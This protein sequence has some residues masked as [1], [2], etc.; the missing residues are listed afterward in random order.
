MYNLKRDVRWG[1]LFVLPLWIT[2]SSHAASILVTAETDKSN[3]AVG[4]TTVVTVRAWVEQPAGDLD[5]I[6][7]FDLDLILGDPSVLSV[8]PGSVHRPDVHAALGGSDGTLANWGIDSIAG[9]YWE[10]TK[11]VGTPQ[12]LFSVD[13]TAMAIGNSTVAAG[14]DAELGT[15]FLLYESS[16]LN[17][18]YSGAVVTLQV[19]PEPSGLVLW[20]AA[21]LF[22][23]A[24]GRQRE[25]HASRSRFDRETKPCINP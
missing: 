11:G 13:V 6:F 15:D 25:G 21:G 5:G 16:T 4:E 8:V 1:I 17:V 3:L 19:V 18:D 10:D 22:L 12:T 24:F 14:P 7:T 2:A 9:G 23:L 20:L